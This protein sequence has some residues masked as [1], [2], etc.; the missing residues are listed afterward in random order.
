MQPTGNTLTPSFNAPSN[1]AEQ[2][3]MFQM[4]PGYLA[5][6]QQDQLTGHITP[7]DLQPRFV[8]PDM[9]RLAQEARSQA[10]AGPDIHVPRQE[11]IVARPVREGGIDTDEQL[12][13]DEVAHDGPAVRNVRMATLRDANPE[14]R[15]RADLS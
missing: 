14:Q 10:I 15:N 5:E 3:G 6:Q 12:A 9:A 2:K 4:P 11:Q 7:A 8:E 13:Y 1:P